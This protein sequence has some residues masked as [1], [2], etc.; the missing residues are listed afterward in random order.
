MISNWHDIYSLIL[1][2][3]TWRQFGLVAAALGIGVC[4]AA[5]LTTIARVKLGLAEAHAALSRFITITIYNACI[6]SCL[7][8]V[9]GV[10]ESVV[11]TNSIALFVGQCAFFGIITAYVWIF[12]NSWIIPLGLLTSVIVVKFLNHL[13]VFTT[14]ITFLNQYS[15]S[16][17]TFSL[18]PLSFIK[19]VLSL[20]L[21]AWLA[22]NLAK[23]T[24]N[25]IGRLTHIKPPTRELLKKVVA[26]GVYTFA[27]LF[28]LHLAGIKLTALAVLGGGL[29]VGIGL[30]LQKIAAN[31]VSGIIILVE[32]N[33][34]KGDL[35]EVQGGP[36][37][38]NTGTVKH[39]GSRYTLLESGDGREVL[40]PNEDFVT[41][42]VT[43]W[44]LSSTRAQVLLN[45][46][47]VYS[48]D[49]ALVKKLLL[50]AAAEHPNCLLNPAPICLITQF[51]ER[52]I[53]FLLQFT[54]AD[55]TVGRPNIQSDVMFTI[56][57]KFK[58]NGIEFAKWPEGLASIS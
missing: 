23:F 46:D 39:F 29:S 31:F 4:M 30:G 25:Q 13:K 52:G 55:V 27:V 45:V 8:A 53:R 16:I 10:S 49:V 5:L 26:V 11:G 58:D 41:Q 7:L 17:G 1:S 28:S 19:M 48:A 20:L 21:L 50:A 43:N 2:P 34:K 36:G 35:I 32:G 12:T 6:F 14:A 51:A 54:I 3:V 56:H 37:G 57:Q 22:T 9:I 47:V 40:I 42:R 33:F 18:T 24:Q 15:V 38:V 44:T